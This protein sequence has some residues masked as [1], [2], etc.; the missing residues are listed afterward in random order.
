[1]KWGGYFIFALKTHFRMPEQDGF[2]LW[3]DRPGKI[4]SIMRQDLRRL[5]AR[6][7]FQSVKAS[8]VDARG[9][10]PAFT[11]II[12]AQPSVPGHSP[13]SRSY[14]TCPARCSQ[15]LE[16][17]PLHQVAAQTSSPGPQLPLLLTFTARSSMPCPTFPDSTWVQ[18]SSPQLLCFNNVKDI[19]FS[20]NWSGL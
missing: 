12:P 17:T 1:M 2:N 5:T 19:A 11:G 8:A 9:P 6:C 16:V 20:L 7:S 13:K 10:S 18:I 4:G 14:K 3:P 15:Q